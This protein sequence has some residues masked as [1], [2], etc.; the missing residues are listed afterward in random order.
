[1]SLNNN[2]SIL[3]GAAGIGCAGSLSDMLN[4][5]FGIYVDDN[6]N[7]YVADSGNNRVQRFPDGVS[8]GVSETTSFILN[9]PTGVIL[10][11]D[12]YLFIVDSGNQRIIRSG[13][14]GYEC[15]IGCSM[16]SCTLPT[17]LCDPLTAI[18]DS[19]GNIFVTNQNTN[20]IQKFV[21][22]T[23]SCGKI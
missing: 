16:P 4:Q 7:L 20:G 5:P 6:F 12:G 15:L 13:P 3:M 1:M 2:D 22:S 17:Q 14:N 8:N 21:L 18:F 9:K 23:N 10:D 19:N 11:G